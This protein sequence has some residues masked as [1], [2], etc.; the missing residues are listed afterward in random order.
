MVKVFNTVSAY[1]LN[2]EWP[3]HTKQVQKTSFAL[4]LVSPSILVMK[5]QSILRTLTTLCPQVPLCGNSF[6]AK[7]KAAAIVRSLGFIPRDCGDL[8]QA[9]QLEALPLQMYPS[10]KW[11][12]VFTGALMVFYWLIFLFRYIYEL[13]I[14]LLVL[15]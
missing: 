15:N 9:R 2:Q 8:R 6:S 10:W 13:S 7:Q 3:V 5:V 14:Y 12:L 4:D 1:G 11:P